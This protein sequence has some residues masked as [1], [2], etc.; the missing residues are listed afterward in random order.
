M[1]VA[2]VEEAVA[3]LAEVVAAAAAGAVS[4]RPRGALASRL[5][6]YGAAGTGGPHSAVACPNCSR[7]V[8]TGFRNGRNSPTLPC[9]C[10]RF[11]RH[12]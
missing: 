5:T 3:V 1:G 4:S 2:A 6:T 11:S 7:A 9:V 12:S 8:S 10:P